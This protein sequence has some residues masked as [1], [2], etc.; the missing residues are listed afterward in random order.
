MITVKWGK[1][2]LNSKSK[3]PTRIG[4]GRGDVHITKSINN[5][6]FYVKSFQYDHTISSSYPTSLKLY[7]GD[8]L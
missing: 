7:R 8:N 4:D 6:N 5:I 3:Y 1:E 2:S